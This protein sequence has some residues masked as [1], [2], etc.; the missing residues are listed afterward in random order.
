MSKAIKTIVVGA[1]L[2]CCVIGVCGCQSDSEY[3]YNPAYVSIYYSYVDGHLS[4]VFGTNGLSWSPAE[5]TVAQYKR[6][7]HEL[8]EEDMFVYYQKLGETETDKICVAFGYQGLDDYLIQHDYVDENGD[9][10]IYLCGDV[11]YDRITKEMRKEYES[12]ENE[13]ETTEEIQSQ[14]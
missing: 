3:E 7:L 4:S 12:D 10:D 11:T 6:I 13:S 1:L 5:N 2:L 9:P 8:N 14:E